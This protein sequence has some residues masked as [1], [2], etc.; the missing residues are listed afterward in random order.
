MNITY[1]RHEI[2]RDIIKLAWPTIIEQVLIMMVG[3]VSTILV[4]K[5]GKESIAAV[6][7]VNNLVNFSQTIFAGLSIGSTIIIARVTGESGIKNAK[8]VLVQSLFMSVFVGISLTFLGIVFSNEIITTFFGAAD[9]KVISLVEIYYHIVLLGMPF[10]VIEMVIGGALRGIGD[11]R[12]PMYVVLFENLMN[13]LLSVVLIYGVNYN[14]VFYLNPLGVKGAAIAATTARII[15]GIVIVYFLFRKKSKINLIKFGKFK[16]NFKIIKRIIRV[17]IPACIENL[18]M[19]GGFLMQ[20]ILVVAMGTVEVAAFQIGGSIHSLAFLPLLGLGLTT[21]TTVGQSLGSK[22][23]KKAEA[24]AYENIKI[25][26]FTGLCSTMIEFFG[27]FLFARLYSSDLQVINT[28]IIVIRGFAL[29]SSFLGVEKVGSAIL[30]CSGDIK[31][32]IF[33]SVAGLWTFRL[34]VAAI[35]IRFLN[36]GLYGLMI[37]IFLDYSIRAVMYIFRIKAGRWK[38]LKV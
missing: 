16:I 25:A 18:I 24:Y 5:L 35:L 2:R 11:T 26:I 30:R 8:E 1:S 6:G 12:T 37:G 15:G 4:S 28:S 27:G 9:S 20:Q 19:N 31:Y 14:E 21:T 32:V 22:D 34:I 29:V 10:V 7:M 33:S 36:L 23:L 17:G 38:C 3:I 13:V